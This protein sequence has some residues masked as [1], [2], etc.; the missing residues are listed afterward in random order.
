[1]RRARE[2][3]NLPPKHLSVSTAGS[4]MAALD[5]LGRIYYLRTKVD[6]RRLLHAWTV[7]RCAF[8]SSLGGTRA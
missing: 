7:L 3:L 5:T 4:E 2:R 6:G 8:C 1:M